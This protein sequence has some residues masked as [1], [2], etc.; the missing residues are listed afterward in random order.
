MFWLLFPA[1]TAVTAILGSKY[2]AKK[3][4]LHLVINS[5]NHSQGYRPGEGPLTARVGGKFGMCIG[6]RRTPNE[7]NLWL[8]GEEMPEMASLRNT[9]FQMTE[10]EGVEVQALYDE[11]L[12][13]ITVRKDFWAEVEAD[14]EAKAITAE[15]QRICDLPDNFRSEQDKHDFFRYSQILEYR[16]KMIEKTNT[17]LTKNVY[18]CAGLLVRFLRFIPAARS[19]QVNPSDLPK[20]PVQQQAA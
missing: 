4:P 7:E 18:G 1:V 19:P 8:L 11:V 12:R 10:A 14:G 9:H 17:A 20:L 13:H 16:A 3:V 15:A 5:Y 6:A 2:A